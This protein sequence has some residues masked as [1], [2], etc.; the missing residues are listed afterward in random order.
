M[1]RID[2]YFNADSKLLAACE[3]AAR[4]LGRGLRVLVYAPDEPVAA[5]L[6]LALSGFPEIRWARLPAPGAS[7]EAPVVIA[8][9]AGATVHDEVLLNLH[10]GAPRHFSRFL[11][12]IEVVAR[13]EDDRQAARERFRYYRDR[14][15]AIRH[16]DMALA[17][18]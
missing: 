1:T 2:F 5:Q 6:E 12:L 13:A 16:H 8:S 3:L 18:A 7:A 9:D 14:G 17:R 15:Y 10:D 11:R 4:A